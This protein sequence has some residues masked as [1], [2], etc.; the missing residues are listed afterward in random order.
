MAHECWNVKFGAI[1]PV[2]KIGDSWKDQDGHEANTETMHYQCETAE[3]TIARIWNVLS[4]YEESVAATISDM[5][6][7]VSN[8][9]KVTIV[10]AMWS[11][12]AKIGVIFRALDN[13]D[14]R[15]LQSGVNA[16]PSYEREARLLGKKCV[17]FMIESSG[18]DYWNTSAKAST[19]PVKGVTQERLSLVTGLA[20]YLK[21]LI[22][23]GLKASL[24]DLQPF[25]QD[26]SQDDDN[27]GSKAI[28][29]M[30]SADND[31]CASCRKTVEDA[32][33]KSTL[34]QLWHHGCLECSS[35]HQSDAFVAE[36]LSQELTSTK[37]CRFCG[38][39]LMQ[40]YYRVTRLQQFGHLLWLAL[41]RY[42][43]A[44]KIDFSVLD[45][46]NLERPAKK[47]SMALEEISRTLEDARTG[48][49]EQRGSD[50]NRPLS[51]SGDEVMFTTQSRT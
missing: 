30:A 22:R 44:N 35:C 9:E 24:T 21:L 45:G 8:A 3:A 31:L 17:A 46:I 19:T 28:S 32:C 51:F 25:L 41:A 38:A 49:S 34:G 37:S 14:K 27:P 50:T 18:F 1:F 6:L 2:K 11:F 26:M 40:G 13:M 23:I 15:K 4:S 36:N 43:L 47:D 39:D 5:L 12:L 42:V 33:Y 20:H 7:A 29:S 16:G 48:A 10:R